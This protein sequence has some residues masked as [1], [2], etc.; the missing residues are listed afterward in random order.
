MAQSD[1][2]RTPA[3]PLPRGVKSAGQP[4][5]PPGRWG[6]AERSGVKWSKAE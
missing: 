4:A 5:D 6:I 3:R 1:D 2:E